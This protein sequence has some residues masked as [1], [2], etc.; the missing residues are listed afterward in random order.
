MVQK[1]KLDVLEN[2]PEL[3]MVE[4]NAP[5][6]VQ[7][8]PL[9]ISGEG[10]AFNKLILIGAPALIVVLI[11]IGALW[12]Y[13][14][15]TITSV[16]KSKPDTSV[17]E[18]EKKVTAGVN[19][20]VAVESV[21]ISTA[22]FKDFVIDLKDKTGRSKILLCDVAFNLSEGKNIAELEN[23]K[24]VRNLIYQ[25]VRGKNSV[26]LKTIEERKLLKKEL[27][28]E[29]NKMIGDGIVKNIYFINYL[30]M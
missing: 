30:I 4:A 1:A 17:A 18:I 10:W 26:A 29:L 3:E 24:D 28:Q 8:E 16:V 15:R 14:S 13:L 23:S 9:P 21:K 2:L 27:S 6:E 12:F 22:Y 19:I 7:E 5:T 25:T 20:P 11:I